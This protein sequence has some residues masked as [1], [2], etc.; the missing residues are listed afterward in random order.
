MTSVL[1][2]FNGLPLKPPLPIAEIA[3]S[4]VIKFSRLMVVLVAITPE[5]L[6]TARISTISSNCSL[7]RSG[8]IFKRIGLGVV[9]KII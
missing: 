9:F 2:S 6:V 1:L 4:E 3:L 5:I 8:A 7:V